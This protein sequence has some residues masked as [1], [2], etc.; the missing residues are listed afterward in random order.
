MPPGMQHGAEAGGTGRTEQELGLSHLGSRR[1][2]IASLFLPTTIVID[3]PERRQRRPTCTLPVVPAG[4]L[5]G[6]PADSQVPSNSSGQAESAEGPSAS[7]FTPMTDPTRPFRRPPKK[8]PTPSRA[9]GP[10]YWHV[11]TSTAG[12]IGLQNAVRSVS[13]I[14]TQRV[15]VG[16]FSGCSTDAWSPDFR[17]L[18]E[19]R[20][21]E[22]DGETHAPVWVS[23]LELTGHYD[24]FCKQVSLPVFC[25]ASWSQSMEA[26]LQSN[27]YKPFRTRSCGNHFTMSC[28]ITSGAR[29]SSKSAGSSIGQ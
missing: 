22:W 28:V 24:Q 12:N 7:L 29:L 25:V 8:A 4:G 19:E 5:V 1:L 15:W 27:L 20:M 6:M 9:Q 2:I 21:Q 13:H 10:L 11:E 14:L 16:T 18:V 23:D 17:A 3:E 26:H